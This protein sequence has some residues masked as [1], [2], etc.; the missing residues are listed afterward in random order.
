[1][2]TTIREK[3]LSA[4]W[5]AVIGALLAAGLIL[6]VL[7]ALGMAGAGA[8][9]WACVLTATCCVILGL[10]GVFRW[11]GLAV[12]AAILFLLLM[13][14]GTLSSMGGL[15]SAAVHLVRG[16]L[17]PLKVFGKEAALLAGCLLTFAGCAMAR[18]SAGFYPALSL[19]MI[20]ILLIWFSGRRDS[21][22]L[23]APALI[24]LCAM[25]ARSAAEETPVLRILIA[26]ALAVIL[27]LMVTPVLQVRS[28]QM[29]KFADNLRNYISDTMFFTEPRSVYS[30]Q[31]DGYKPLETRLGGPVELTD[32]PVMT[33]E[34]PISV[35]LRGVVYNEYNGLNWSDGMSSRRY[36][37]S[38]PR[39]RNVRADTLDEKR[40]S[41]E[42]QA[43]TD[44]FRMA[45]I[46]ITMQSDNASTLFVPQRVD[47]LNTPMDLVPYFNLSGELFTTRNLA[48][49]DTYSFSAP[50][51]NATDSRLPNILA[52]AALQTTESRDMSAY[53]GLHE[54]I[55]PDV[56]TLTEQITAS[57]GTPYDRA[58][59]IQT[60]LQKTYGY[61]TA[62][63][64]PPDNQDFVSYFLLRGRRG[65][66]TY[67][68]SAMAIMGRIAGLPT[69]Y[70]EGYIADP[71]GGVSLVTS[72]QAHAWTEVYFD[73]FGWV[74]F[75]ATPPQGGSGRSA[76][77]DPG[78]EDGMNAESE[79]NE[80][81][82]EQGQEE[83]ATHDPN[84]TPSPQPPEGGGGDDASPDETPDGNAGDEP[85]SSPEPEGEPTPTPTP[86]PP[87][88]QAF[89]QNDNTPDQMDNPGDG[90][91]KSPSFWWLWLILLAV[92]GFAVWCG[93]WT[94]PEQVSSRQATESAKLLAW[95][96]ALLGLLASAGMPARTWETPA[97]YAERVEQGIPKEAGFA[98]V[99]SMITMLGYARGGVNQ[100]D[101]AFA[102]SCYGRVWRSMPLNVKVKWLMHRMVHGLGSVQQVP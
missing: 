64:I 73:G 78:L 26:S 35:L 101:V 3:G 4:V 93:I 39:N 52:E 31:A 57:A 21:L 55:A 60:Y 44:L 51:I 49:M 54:Q 1:M 68:A 2:L 17:E 6:P 37:F 61:T 46:T 56:Y 48:P 82:P 65:Y 100:A 24:A 45:D 96:R 75:D 9:V 29:E 22:W 58:R 62:P 69:R 25:F 40:P 11:I 19:T 99:A 16:N 28:P 80:Q 36:L 90:N 23:F 98:E 47:N 50:V 38:D 8:A 76:T 91:K 71:S 30:I 59:A 12:S 79:S 18:Q 34:T 77:N 102:A 10:G 87:E 72:K 84:A 42:I 7:S 67:F 94:S 88:M 32:R 41:S 81:E 13:V 97:A 27:A 43:Q 14:T 83:D 63:E 5:P 85:T 74:A 20:A 92:A 53:M 33:V 66:C 15:L 89:H 95:Y 70:V 86:V